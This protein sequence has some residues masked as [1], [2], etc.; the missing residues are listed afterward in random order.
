MRR[1]WSGPRL[2]R[3]AVIAACMLCAG[4]VSAQI[5][6]INSAINKAGRQ[7]MLSQRMAKAYFQLGQGVDVARS[8][9]ALDGSIALFDRQ[10]AE[11]NSYAPTADIRD[12]YLS[13][14]RTWLTYKAALTGTAPNKANGRTVL[15]I[16]E[17][18]LKLAHQGT[19]QLEKHAGSK[20]GHL[21]NV[22]GRQ[23]MLS[24]RMAK[25]Y[26]AINWGIGDDASPGELERVRKEFVASHD[27]LQ[28]A[29]G[30]AGAL[31]ESL[32]RV[33]RQ[34]IFLEAALAQQGGDR[35]YFATDVAAAS[36]LVLQ[37]MELTVGLFEK[38]SK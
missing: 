30:G 5:A 22:A 35:L 19:V 24:Q 31:K 38:M 2:A 13:L 37:E 10:L 12:I 17:D 25:Y 34:W 18:V 4:G 27:E 14:Q 28:Q 3:I 8:Q 11:L 1:Y 26:Q 9:R 21:V 6:D 33:G 23:R 15:A 20:A 36:E 16:S 32:D 7:R 29:A